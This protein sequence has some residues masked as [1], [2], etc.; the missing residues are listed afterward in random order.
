MKKLLF[1]LT[2]LGT[3]TSV[4]C[5]H[6]PNNLPVVH[7]GDTLQGG[8]VFYVSATHQHGLVC[9][10]EDQGAAPWDTTLFDVK[11]YELYNPPFIGGTDTATG[12]GESNTSLIINRIG[13]AYYAATLCRSYNSDG[14]NNWSLPSKN[15][16]YMMYKNLHLKGKGNFRTDNPLCSSCPGGLYWTS[17][18]IDN[19][20]VWCQRF[21][22]GEQLNNSWK[23][24][25]M[26]VRAVHSF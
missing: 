13:N 19:R 7:I 20:A 3:I 16:L 17:S 8:I 1:V 25:Q 14:Y 4:S 5:S 2:V 15:E 18:E 12:A 22:T 10:L 21:D 26:F 24:N 6:L 11:N 23:N 9:A